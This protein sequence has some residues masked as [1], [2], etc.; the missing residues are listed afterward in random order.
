MFAL[1]FSDSHRLAQFHL[2][3]IFSLLILFLYFAP[4][5]PSTCHP[6]GHFLISAQCTNMCPGKPNAQRIKKQS[7]QS[8]EDETPNHGE[9]LPRPHIL[10]LNFV[11]EG[12]PKFIRG[13]AE[14]LTGW[15]RV[16]SHFWWCSPLGR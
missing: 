5:N 2:L 16:L 7:V 3:F 10:K 14:N 9:A 6:T 15:K 8:V 12:Q 13:A 11:R 4:E 1:N